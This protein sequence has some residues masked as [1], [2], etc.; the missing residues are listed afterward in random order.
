MCNVIDIFICLSVYPPI[1][2]TYHQHNTICNFIGE[3]TIAVTFTVILQH[4]LEYT[5]EIVPS[6]T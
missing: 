5:N 2:I 1:N 6:V 3:L 4:S